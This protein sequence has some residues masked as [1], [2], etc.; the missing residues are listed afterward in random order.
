MMKSREK[1]IAALKKF[2][3]YESVRTLVDFR[4]RKEVNKRVK[5]VLAQEI[6]YAFD[7]MESAEA[8]VGSLKIGVHVIEKNLV[9]ANRN[10]SNMESR[11]LRLIDQVRCLVSRYQYPVS[12][13]IV[14][15]VIGISNL[16]C[17]E[18]RDSYGCETLKK[19]LNDFVSELHVSISD[20]HEIR[21]QNKK[22]VEL[23]FI[24]ADD[25][26]S[27]VK[28]RHSIREMKKD[29][30]SY[31]E[32]KEIVEIAQICPSA[33]NRQS[34]K[35]YYTS[36]SEKLRKLFPDSFVT[37]DIYNMLLVTVNKSYYSTNEALQAWIDGGI[38]LESMVMAM[39]SHRLG[40][41]LFQC[42]KNTKRYYQVKEAVGIPEN[43][44]IVAFIG[45]GRLKDEYKVISTH[46]KEVDEV[47]VDFTNG[48]GE[49]S[50]AENITGCAA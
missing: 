16:L 9:K 28:S 35:V 18:C 2:H 37:K 50:L 36:D 23:D 41:C 10:Y 17:Y 8:I 34:T 19:T 42:L 13:D 1:L 27:F 47:L 33:C 20:G 43:E 48:G 40:T 6:T 12:S 29:I 45:Y 15:E 25:Y 21:I 38:F 11:C 39:H 44:D 7:C 14:R 3:L 30:V 49:N 24:D 31:E 32:I 46:R 26:Q 5:S 22:A 4:N